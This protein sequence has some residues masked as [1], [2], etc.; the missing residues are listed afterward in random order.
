M[1]HFCV[2]L[3]IH[4]IVHSSELHSHPSSH[5]PITISAHSHQWPLSH[6]PPHHHINDL[7]H[8]TSHHHINS[9]SS[10]SHHHPHVSAVCG[11]SAPRP[12]MPWNATSSTCTLHTHWGGNEWMRKWGNERMCV[13]EWEIGEC[14]WLRKW[15][16]EREWKRGSERERECDWESESEKMRE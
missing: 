11:V 9:H 14:V 13:S 4:L 12:H 2:S 1:H 6:H 16:N 15:G 5:S 7:P 3:F 10:P 8:I